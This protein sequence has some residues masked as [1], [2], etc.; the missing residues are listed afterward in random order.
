MHAGALSAIYGVS[1]RVSQMSWVLSLPTICA[2]SASLIIAAQIMKV[3]LS[4][5][6][7]I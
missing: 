4:L 6:S 3:L 2:A 5:G 1:I 7:P